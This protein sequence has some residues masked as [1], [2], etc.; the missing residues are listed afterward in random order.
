MVS[1]IA[2]NIIKARTELSLEYGRAKYRAYFVT[3]P[4]YKKYKAEVD[5]IL[6]LDG[7]SD[8]IVT[9]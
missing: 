6:V 5:A 9:E 4:Y 1:F 8:C 3:L 7:Y 2:N